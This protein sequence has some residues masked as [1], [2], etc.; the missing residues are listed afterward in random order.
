NPRKKQSPVA[1]PLNYFQLASP[2]R[3]LCKNRFW[4][5]FRMGMVS[6]EQTDWKSPLQKAAWS[7]NEVPILPYRLE[8]WVSRCHLREMVYIFQ[9]S[10]SGDNYL[11]RRRPLHVMPW[12]ALVHASSQ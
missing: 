12:L 11:W 1:H 6:R 2:L 7:P 3:P 5:R 10:D 4:G 9:K 8:E